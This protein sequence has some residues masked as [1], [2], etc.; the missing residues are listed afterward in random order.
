MNQLS[1]CEFKIEIMDKRLEHNIIKFV[2]YYFNN[3]HLNGIIA[4]NATLTGCCV[5]AWPS[6]GPDFVSFS[7]M[8]RGRNR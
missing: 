8:A 7:C 5:T 4:R 2:S 6:V 1:K 3:Y